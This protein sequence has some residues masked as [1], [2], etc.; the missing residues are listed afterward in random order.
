MVDRNTESYRTSNVQVADTSGNALTQAV[1]NVG[2]DIIK[3]SQEAKIAENFSKA[4]L[5]LG[6]LNQKYQ[7][8]YQGNPLGGM[9]KLKAAQQQIF[10]KYGGEISPFFK[11]PWNDSVRELGTQNEAKTQA[12]AYGQ[13][14]QNT[15]QSVNTAI[16]NSLSQASIDGEAIGNGTQTIAGAMVNFAQSHKNLIGMANSLGQTDGTKMLED[17]KEDYMKSV[18]S[19]MAQ[20]NPMMALKSMDDP[21]VKSSFSNHEQYTKMKEAIGN[22]ALKVQEVNAEKEVLGILKNENS[23]LAK[24]MTAP[25]SWGE[26]QQEFATNKTSLSAQAF[27]MK[28]NGFTKADGTKNIDLDAQVKYQ[29]DL[30]D[31]IISTTSK[32]DISAKDVSELQ[33]K[34]YTGM[35]NGALTQ[36]EGVDYL[37]H[38]LTPVADKKSA[39]LDNFS[40][41]VNNPFMDNLGFDAVKTAFT[42]EFA[43]K[44]PDGETPGPFTVKRD[45]E[46]KIK[47]FDYYKASLENEAGKLNIPYGSIPD[48]PLGQRREIYQRAQDEAKTLYLKE[49]YP[50]LANAKEMPASIVDGNGKKINTGLGNGKPSGSVTVSKPTYSFNS[51]KEMEE[52]KLPAGT[53][54]FVNGVQGNVSK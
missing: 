3:T 39:T 54:V 53:P 12:W 40:S 27:F 10:D 20:T 15:V 29:S 25:I 23:L 33:Q 11:K 52:A 22:R 2:Q 31:Q 28:A 26:L 7:T 42:S 34:V 24:S 46:N 49:K 14:R 44:V 32:P 45:N 18:L 50:D 35:A 8:D 30:Y 37:N 51:L 47:L 13:M 16:K 48:L 38:L 41:G 9:D 4:Q 36:K 21:A 1:V 19:D 6:Q 5:E 17:H 43:T